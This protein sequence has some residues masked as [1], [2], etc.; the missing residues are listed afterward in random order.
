[1]RRAARSFS[2]LILATLAAAPPSFVVAQQRPAQPARPAPQKPAEPAPV[3]PDGPAYEPQLLKLAEIIG[4]LAYLRTLCAASD[5][6]AW[7]DRMSALVEAEGRTPQRRN[8]LTSS[9][10]RG[11]RAYA[12][13]HRNCTDASQE[14]AS[15]LAAE[16]EQL[17]KALA[18]RYGG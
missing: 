17:S 9:Y 2:A 12:L 13:T 8:R 6:Q 1:M 14:A 11:F 5:A 18:G 10:N 4:S 7:R 3:E 15:R 16:G